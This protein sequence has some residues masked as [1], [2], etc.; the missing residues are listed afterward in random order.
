[1]KGLIKQVYGGWSKL[2]TSKSKQI[3]EIKLNF[4][5]KEFGL[6]SE[7]E[8]SQLLKALGVEIK[9]FALFEQAL[10]HRSYIQVLADVKSHSNER[11]EFLGDSVLGMIISEYLFLKNPN[12]EEGELTKMRSWLV[13]KKT[14]A[15]CAQKLKLDK[16]IKLSYSAEKSLKSGSESILADCLEAI[17]AAIYLDSGLEV[18]KNFVIEGLVPVMTSKN[19]MVDKNYKSILLEAVQALGLPAPVYHV[20]SEKG[21]DHDKEFTVGVYINDQLEGTGT[22]KS[23]KKAEQAAAQMAFE[24]KFFNI[25]TK[26]TH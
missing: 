8:K 9:N 6:F 20:I 24:T 7:E 16:F 19:V 26:N 21:P 22:G 3:E 17:I 2:F 14:L 18:T 10:I 5:I 23:K 11:L 1:M 12:L 25:E 13:N 15:I 4:E